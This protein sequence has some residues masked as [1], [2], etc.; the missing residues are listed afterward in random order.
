MLVTGAGRQM[1]MKYEINPLSVAKIFLVAAALALLCGCAQQ[2]VAP[3]HRLAVLPLTM[4]IRQINRMAD[5]IS[6]LRL[7]GSLKITYVSR[8]NRPGSLS[9][10]AVL[11][12][13]RLAAHRANAA[14]TRHQAEVLLLTTY[15]GQNAMELGVN[16]SGYWLINH[17]KNIAYIGAL[18]ARGQTPPGVLPLNPADLLSLLGF[19]AVPTDGRTIQTVVPGAADVQLLVLGYH[20][21]QLIVSRQLAISRYTGRITQV[22]LFNSDARATAICHMTHYPALAPDAIAS[23]STPIS[24][25]ICRQFSIVVP[26]RRMTIQFNVHHVYAKLPGK[27]RF[28]FR[29]PS[30]RGDKV[31]IIVPFSAAH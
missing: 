18:D 31:H 13:D 1:R 21:G 27:A 29:R 7:T 4:Q 19:A 12:V 3:S 9:L 30:L 5:R 20:H 6:T 10:H 25:L 17:Q 11:L 16:R 28:I 15:L 22:T 23:S 24:N 8:H 2:P 14:S 26:S